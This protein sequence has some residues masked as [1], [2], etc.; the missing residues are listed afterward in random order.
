[1]FGWLMNP[2]MLGLGALAVASPILIHLL[3]RRRFKIIEWAAMDF[4]FEADKKNRRRVQLENFILLFLR[5]LA[6]LLIGLLLARPYLP[7][8][9]AELMQPNQKY[10]RIFLVDDSLSSRVLNGDQPSINV[11]RNALSRMVAEFAESDSSED[12]LTVALTSN[13]DQPILANEPVTG[14]TL[15]ALLETID[16]IEPTDTRAN[17]TTSI[18][19][20]RRVVAASDEKVTRV[21]YLFSDLRQQDWQSV[22][23]AEG[24][25]APN[26]LAQELAADSSECFLVDLGSPADNN[27]AITSLRPLDL[28]V[29]NRVVRFAV[30]VTNYGDSSIGGV[31]VLFQVDDSTPQYQT[32]A[33]LLPG[34]TEEVVF[35][36]LFEDN[37]SQLAF[38]SL[39][40]SSLTDFRNYKIVAEIDRQT[41]TDDDLRSDQLINDS[42]A[43][44][45]AR[46]FS[47]VPI[48]L[49][50][51]DPSSV[52]ER[53]E[54]HYLNSL[55]V[56][57]TGLRPEAV[58][59][60]DLETVSLSD[61]QIIFLCNV[62]EISPERLRSI[63]N[64]IRDG[65]NLVLM[66]GNK[67]RSQTFNE[68]FHEDGEG[69]SPLALN[70]IAGDPTMSS[71]VNFEV[72]PQV[73]PAFQIVVD[74]DQ[75]SL[76]R[77][78]IFSW[79]T[80]TLDTT[81]IGTDFIVPLRL[82]DDQNSVAMA[83]RSWGDGRVIVFTIP[84]DG[85]WSMWPSSPTYAP[86]MI[87]M[88]DYLVGSV[89]E[90]ASVPVGGTIGY[91]V[92]LSAFES[93]VVLKDP[94][95]ER[96]ESIARPV[97]QKEQQDDILGRVQFDS[98]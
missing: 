44:C 62:D 78:D 88:I 28:Q 98:I 41:M 46:I 33:N 54:T 91:P 32:V 11:A 45:A 67:I 34:Q 92:D 3:N 50:D 13:P 29:S 51:G 58:T 85:D 53:S 14:E 79:W 47:G 89:G 77:V 48:L 64:W 15:P 73:H 93:R 86:V 30:D 9:L 71:W 96:T 80:S 23:Y 4:L 25:M 95:D 81:K 1:M 27:L 36:F 5:C 75:T 59:T 61:Y 2:W 97:N 17:Y 65:G 60:T 22:E 39:D 49:V 6:M 21:T 68:C 7:S 66:P 12:W 87:D 72:A 94:N 10:E 90:N 84:G 42:K 26:R 35:P 8:Q 24:Q 83:E 56:L 38:D 82:S 16:N 18:S 40:S 69:L 43:F 20:L 37:P 76:S 63:K 31:K 74:S 57:G 70:S 52:A 55:N 19:E